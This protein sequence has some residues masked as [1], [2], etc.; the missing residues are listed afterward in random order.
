MAPIPASARILEEPCSPHVCVLDRIHFVLVGR[1]CEKTARAA[2]ETSVL[3]R[4]TR[5]DFIQQL[6]VHRGL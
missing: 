2:F 3:D 6:T 1:W 5:V 4:V